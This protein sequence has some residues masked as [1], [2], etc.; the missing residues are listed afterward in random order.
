MIGAAQIT[1]NN[2]KYQGKKIN[3]SCLFDYLFFNVTDGGE[4]Q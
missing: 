3:A 4:L 1:E 2:K